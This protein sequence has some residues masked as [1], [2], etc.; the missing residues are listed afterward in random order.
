MFLLMSLDAIIPEI[1]SLVKINPDSLRDL[2]VLLITPNQWLRVYNGRT[3]KYTSLT[4]LHFV[5]GL[6]HIE[7]TF[8]ISLPN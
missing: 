8:S 6:K 3:E 2:R 4:E 5:R 1:E 7:E